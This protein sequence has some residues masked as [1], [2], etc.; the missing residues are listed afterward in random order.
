M[1]KKQNQ[2]LLK[3]I[4]QLNLRYELRF[5]YTLKSTYNNCVTY[6][7]EI[8]F[9]LLYLNHLDIIMVQTHP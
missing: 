9:F 3:Q 7:R 8:G 6:E 1:L 2:D 4:R 5:A